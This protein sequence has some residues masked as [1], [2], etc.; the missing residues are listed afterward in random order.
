MKR[1]IRPFIFL[2]IF[3]FFA[4]QILRGT[5]IVGGGITYKFLRRDGNKITYHFTMKMYKDI[6]LSNPQ[7]DF[8]DPAYIAIYLDTNNGYKLFGNNG[9][10]QPIIQPIVQPRRTVPNPD[11]PCFVAPSNIAV[12]EAVYEW[13]AVLIDTTYSY[14]VSYQKCCRNR[15]IKNIYNPGQSGSTYSIEITPEAQHLNNSSAVFKYFPPIFICNG[16]P[17]KFDHSAADD[18]GDQLVYSFCT[19]YTSPQG[20]QQNRVTPPP[21]PYREVSYVQPDY[22]ATVP[23]G[24]DPVITIDANTGLISGTP[25]TLDQFVVSVCVEEYRNGKLLSKMFRDFQFNVVNCQKLVDAKIS[26]DSSFGKQYFIY[27]CENVTLTLNNQSYERKEINSFYWNF[28]IKGEQIISNEWNP[29]ITL[30]DTGEYKAKLVLN[31]NSQCGDSAFLTMRVGGRIK[32]D[33]TIA[34]DTCV[35]GPVA[36][37]GTYK[38]ALPTRSIQWAYGDSTYDYEKTL[39]KHQYAKPGFKNVIFS[40]TDVYGCVGKT[41]KNF[42]WQPAPPFFVIEPD[43]FSGCAPASVFFRNRSFPV[44]STYNITW[45][46]GDGK[47]GKAISPTHIYAKPDTY[48]VKLT[49]ISPLNCRIDTTFRSWIKVKRSPEANFDYNPKQITNFN[50]TIN[51]TDKS[52]NGIFWQ[53]TFGTQVGGY[54]SKQN[55]TFTFR[56]TGLQK[57]RLIVRNTEGCVDSITKIIDVVPIVT[58][59]MPNAFTPNDDAQNDIFRGTGFLYGMKNFTLKIWNRWGELIFNTTNP[60]EGWNGLKFNTG[61]PSP[62]GV[63]LYEVFYTTPKDEKINQ[64]GYATLLR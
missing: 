31:P 19:S 37:S 21:P 26:A 46:F 8:D 38:T 50:P 14:I 52:Y 63:Y 33:F 28:N 54:S 29:T 11:I 1:V 22:T 12:Q 9:N 16:S 61:Q 40:A 32:T 36:F 10:G 2:V 17:L 35:S 30:P 15:T 55:P 3:T 57:V 45:D 25:N 62:E 7:A 34:Y 59:H 27:G 43:K 56:D 58:Y 47:I 51:F 41:V 18:E 13:E 20:G 64:R 42:A 53:W 24:G 48:T 4:P 60:Q 44:D 49:I 39:T 6:Y 23:M 5:H